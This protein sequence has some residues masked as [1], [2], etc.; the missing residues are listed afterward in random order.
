MSRDGN[1]NLKE[2]KRKTNWNFSDEGKL[3]TLAGG[4][5]TYVQINLKFEVVF[6]VCVALR[7]PE[8]SFLS[9]ISVWK[10]RKLIKLSNP[11]DNDDVGSPRGGSS[12]PWN[13]LVKLGFRC[14]GKKFAITFHQI[15]L[16][17]KRRTLELS[18]RDFCKYPKAN[19]IC[20]SKAFINFV[21]IV[22]PTIVSRH[23]RVSS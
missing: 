7:N 8:R 19:L 6:L 23:T 3:K 5:L 16:W 12:D 11:T 18:W 20:L 10:A 9:V 17:R 1:G 14:C 2:V 13:Y 22:I 21:F 4:L 15:V